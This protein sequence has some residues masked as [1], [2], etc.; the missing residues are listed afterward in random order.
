MTVSEAIQAVV[1]GRRLSEEQAA[2]AAGAIMGG[3]ATP[4]QIAGLLVALRMR[5]ETA[6]EIAGFARA[7]RAAATPVTPRSDGLLDTCG[8]GGDASGTFNVSTATGFVAA[9]AGC[10]VAKHGNRAASSMCGSAA[11]SLSDGCRDTTR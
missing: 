7:A 8:T 6:D 3:L 10:R 2:D 4:S 9:A 1:S 11:A 5:G